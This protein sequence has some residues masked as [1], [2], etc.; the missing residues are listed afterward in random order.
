MLNPL[1]IPIF[2]RN[3]N[4]LRYRVLLIMKEHHNDLFVPIHKT[5]WRD[6]WFYISDSKRWWLVVLLALGFLSLSPFIN[7]S[8]LNILKIEPATAIYI[9]DQRAAN[10]AT[11]I[12]IT[13]VVVGFLINNLSVKSPV[14]YRLLFKYS[15]LHPII[16]LTLSTIAY[17]IVVSTLRDTLS[18]FV[19]TRIVLA[20]T[21]LSFVILFLI[22]FLF[23]KVFRFSNKNEIIKILADELLHEASE[24]TKQILLLKYGKQIFN[25][26]MKKKGASEYDWSE[27]WE[28]FNSKIEITEVT[29]KEIQTKQKD[30]K[31]IHDINLVA[32]SDFIS[33]IGL[34]EQHH[35]N[36]PVHLNFFSFHSNRQ[37]I[38]PK[39]RNKILYQKLHLEM[40]I[41]VNTNFIWEKGRKNTEKEK[42]K[43]RSVL[44]M[45]TQS[46]KVKDTEAMRKYFDQE[47]EDSTEHGQYKNIQILLDSYTKLYEFQMQHQ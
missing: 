39:Q 11:I 33:K 1:A 43:L 21:Y 46:A 29:D 23:Q 17:F 6:F 22:G 15:Y 36:W 12:S 25:D 2:R 41:D 45:K 30:F 24:K 42:K 34:N 35:H 26:E 10:I 47:L 9:V 18:S 38:I 32:V 8:F 40:S 5:L 16:Y 31:I 4:W 3:N 13:L 27:N 19:F 20:G 7:L 14:V 37:K 28:Y 44:V